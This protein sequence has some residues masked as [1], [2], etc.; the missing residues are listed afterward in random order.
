MSTHAG[1]N[2]SEDG[3]VLHLDAAQKIKRGTFFYK[4]FTTALSNPGTKSEFDALFTPTP[5]QSG[6]EHD[7]A[8]N[9][10]TLEQRPSYITTPTGFA[11]EVTGFLVIDD[12]GTYIFNTRSDDGNELQINGQ[13]VTSFY[14]V[15]GRGVPP[16]GDVSSP[17]TLQKGIYPFQYRMQQGGGLAGAQV[18]WQK[19]GS[20]A[21][22]VI[23]PFNFA[24]GL[25]NNLFMNLV[26]INNNGSLIGGVGKNNSNQGFLTFDGVNDYITC[27][28]QA[29]LNAGLNQSSFSSWWNYLG[30]GSGTDKR[31][32]VLE[33]ANFHYSLF[34]NTDG[35]LVA[36]INTTLESSQFITN[37]SPIIGNWYHS[38]VV[39]DGTSLILYIN[40]NEVD[41]RSQSGTSLAIQNLRIGTYRDNNNRWW[42]GNISQVSIYNRSLSPQEIKQN[43]NALRGRYGI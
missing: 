43:F 13:V 37:F 41:R 34:V 5:Q 42:L 28:N 7:Q 3:I 20:S 38:V 27:G 35:R 9:W 39:W 18:R 31:G 33:S 23:P 40:G 15:A 4:W 22:E 21:Y 30:Q 24:L 16:V 6:I 32:F 1:P 26:G 36:H 25:D 17:I 14:N 8:I 11:W 2:S 29:V 19:P 10:L 12:P